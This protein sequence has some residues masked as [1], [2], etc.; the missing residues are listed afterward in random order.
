VDAGDP[1]DL[2][3]L[4]RSPF[5]IATPLG[6]AAAY[7]DS[8]NRSWHHCEYPD[9]A[10][11]PLV[12][13]IIHHRGGHLALVYAR[14]DWRA[15][16]GL[17]AW[18]CH[19]RLPMSHL[20]RAG[21]RVSILRRRWWHASLGTEPLAQLFRR[22]RLPQIKASSLTVAHLR[23]HLRAWTR[24]RG[25]F[26]SGGHTSRSPNELFTA[27]RRRDCIR[28]RRDQHADDEPQSFHTW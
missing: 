27:L 16:S 22:P 17:C 12:V 9:D 13:P 21:C 10:E 26:I 20:R 8:A 19:A 2:S 25:L 23:L 18:P 7:A 15:M 14:V 4:R 3:R 5:L 24:P 11:L 1:R 6:V 28:H